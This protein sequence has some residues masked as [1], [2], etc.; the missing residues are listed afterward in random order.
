MGYGASLVSEF[1]RLERG[2]APGRRGNFECSVAPPK[3]NSYHVMESTKLRHYPLVVPVG[4]L[5]YNPD[6]GFSQF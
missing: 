3:E 4:S 1:S 2:L 5:A 6:A